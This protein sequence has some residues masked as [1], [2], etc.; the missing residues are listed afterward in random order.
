MKDLKSKNFNLYT[1]KTLKIAISQ[2]EENKIFDKLI[3]KF[4]LNKSDIF[5]KGQEINFPFTEEIEI[6]STVELYQDSYTEDD[7]NAGI[8]TEQFVMKFSLDF[9]IDGEEIEVVKN[10]VCNES[11]S[12][13][14][15]NHFRIG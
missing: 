2:E 5:A 10:E 11:I 12:D 1:M 14:I 9:M 6:W 4:D 13:R 15:Y 8:V 3:E 7:T